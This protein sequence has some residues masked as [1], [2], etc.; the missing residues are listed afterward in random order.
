MARV[1]NFLKKAAPVVGGFLGGPATS[2]AL[3]A[4]SA[5][6][7]HR[8]NQANRAMAREQMQFQERMSSTAAQRSVED[9]RKAGLNPALAYGQ[10]ASSPAGSTA[11]MGDPINTGVSS[12][13][14]ARALR[15]QL[16]IA[17]D[18]AYEQLNYTKTL[19]EHEKAKGANTLA[20]GRILEQ[21]ERENERAYQFQT[22]L[23][24]SELALSAARALLTANEAA[25]TGYSLPGLRNS[26]AFQEMLGLLAPSGRAAAGAVGALAPALNLFRGANLGIGAA[27]AVA[28]GA[29]GALPAIRA[30]RIP[31]V[32]TP[33]SRSRR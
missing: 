24:P 33:Q 16:R 1:L 7:Q 3:G 9:Y 8:T 4:L 27:R 26:A 19:T 10:V 21:Q 12:A 25:A 6:G 23:Q 2:I 15:Q 20:E 11:T 32:F 17:N 13:Q 28:G 31:S 18:Q 30:G 5:Y 29:R 14:S 22:A